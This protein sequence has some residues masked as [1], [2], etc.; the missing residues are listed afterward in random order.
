VLDVYKKALGMREDDKGIRGANAGDVM[1]FFQY[2]CEQHTGKRRLA[3]TV[4]R[5]KKSIGNFRMRDVKKSGRYLLLGKSRRVNQ[6]HKGRMKKMEAANSEEEK[7]KLFGEYEK[8]KFRS[9][10]ACGVTVDVGL[11]GTKGYIIDGIIPRTGV[12]EYSILN[13][14][15]NMYGIKDCYVIDL[16]EV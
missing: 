5:V 7:M 6:A 3:F 11:N 1:V 9:D 10:H 4:K 8:V 15:K 13:L 16:Y 2:V 12:N 14:A